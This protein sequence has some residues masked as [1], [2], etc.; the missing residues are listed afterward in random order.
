MLVSLIAGLSI[1]LNVLL[2]SMLFS[3]RPTIQIRSG[4][5]RV[6]NVTSYVVRRLP[7]TGR[8]YENLEY[9]PSRN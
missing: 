7:H 5:F 1:G 6:I 9:E 8:V 2:F 3:E 4:P